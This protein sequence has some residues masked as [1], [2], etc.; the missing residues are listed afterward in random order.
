MKLDVGEKT[1]FCY[2]TKMNEN[3]RAFNLE[4]KKNNKQI[5]K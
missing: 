5:N 1:C 3:K 4:M 2:S